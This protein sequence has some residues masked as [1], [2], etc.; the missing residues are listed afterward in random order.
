MKK[1][2]TMSSK[3]MIEEFLAQPALALVG[4]SRSGKK[5]GNFAYRALKSKGYHVYPIHPHAASIDAVRCYSDFATLPEHVENLLVVVPATR[6]V[7]AVR[8]AAAAGIR[9]CVA[10]AG[11]RITGSTGR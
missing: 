3:A 8:T 6:A 4:M 2:G 9:S 1:G 10:A 7:A 11:V 5:F